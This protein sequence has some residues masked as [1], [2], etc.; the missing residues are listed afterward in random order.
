MYDVTFD[1]AERTLKVVVEGFWTDSVQREFAR[2]YGLAIRRCRQSRRP[3]TLLVDAQRFAV[4][5]KSIVAGMA[6]VHDAEA[7]VERAPTAIVVGSAILK[8]QAERTITGDNV[9]VFLEMPVA[10]AWLRGATD[11]D[12]AGRRDDK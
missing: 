9:R 11:R 7:A 2:D 4:Q 1:E 5:P 6:A 3:F 12:A 10:V 8:L